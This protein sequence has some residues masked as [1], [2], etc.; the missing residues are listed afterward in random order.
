MLLGSFGR[1]ASDGGANLQ[2]YYPAS[3]NAVQPVDQI[4]PTTS[5]DIGLSMDTTQPVRLDNVSVTLEGGDESND[6]IQRSVRQ[7]C[8]V[9]RCFL[10]FYYFVSFKHIAFFDK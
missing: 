9:G 6:E 8:N 1:R 2:I 7:G 10:T 5:K 4:Y 3:G